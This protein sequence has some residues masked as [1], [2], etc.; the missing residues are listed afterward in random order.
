MAGRDVNGVDLKELSQYLA[1][2]PSKLPVVLRAGWRLRAR[3]WWRHAP[4]LPLPD[5]AYWDFRLVT[6]TGSLSGTLSI[7]EILDAARWSVRQGVG[8]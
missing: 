2:H 1:R 8:E 4:F 3:R 7:E 6:V 5:K